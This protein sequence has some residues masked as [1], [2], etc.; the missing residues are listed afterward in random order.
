MGKVFNLR[1]DLPAFE[2]A[3]GETSFRSQLTKTKFC[4]H[5]HK[6][7]CHFGSKCAFAHSASE[8]KKMPNLRKTRMCEA[9]LKGHCNQAD[10]KFAHGEGDL[11]K[12]ELFHKTTTC[13][14]YE[15]GKCRYGASCR[16]AH[17]ASELRTPEPRQHVPVK[18]F[19]SP[20]SMTPTESMASE[21]MDGSEGSTTGSLQEDFPTGDKGPTYMTPPEM[22]PSTPP[23]LHCSLALLA[24]PGLP[25]GRVQDLSSPW[26]L[27]RPRLELYPA[28]IPFDASQM[29][30]KVHS[31]LV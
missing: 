6:G 24:A 17:G 7:T 20:G 1:V 25:K 28:V 26:R 30:M 31:S 27:E 21:I 11:T 5:F 23:G 29:P 15:K 8:L 16:F 18:V 13:A 3:A 10:C 14:W 4:S 12:A 19:S 22:A 2:A 9:F